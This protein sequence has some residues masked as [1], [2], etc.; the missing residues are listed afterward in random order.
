MVQIE[1]APKTRPDSQIR[2]DF[3]NSTEA[4]AGILMRIQLKGMEAVCR[5][6]GALAG[7]YYWG[8]MPS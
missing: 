2:P 4:I 8:L 3:Q 1:L 5:R 7:Q 6:A